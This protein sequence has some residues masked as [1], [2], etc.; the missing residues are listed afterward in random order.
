[1][2]LSEWAEATARNLLAEPLPRRW[3]HSQGVADAA[4]ALSSIA[5]DHA[6]LIVAAAFLHDIGYSPAIA[7][8]GFHP[9]DGARHL[10]DAE[11]ADDLLSRLVANHTASATEAFERGLAA[12]LAHEFPPPPPDLADALTYCDI[13]TGPDGQR[14]SADDRLAEILN[15]YEPEDPVHRA[16]T[17]SAPALTAAAARVTRWLSG[18]ESAL[19]P[20]LPT[21]ASAQIRLDALA[22]KRAGRTS[23]A[24]KPDGQASRPTDRRKSAAISSLTVW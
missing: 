16:I 9:L 17:A 1:M 13:T 15:R 21:A 8:T 12:D 11:N 23:Q 4:R 19:G 7:A 20:R 5:G 22:M 10:R 2:P 3:A 6:D 14:M 24:A 18:H